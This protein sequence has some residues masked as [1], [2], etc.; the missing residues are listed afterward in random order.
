MKGVQNLIG[1]IEVAAL[2]LPLAICLAV[3]VRQ[4]TQRTR[5]RLAWT[6]CSVAGALFCLALV[7]RVL[8]GLPA[9]DWVEW[10]RPDGTGFC[11]MDG[12]PLESAEIE[13]ALALHV[14]FGLYLL[15]MALI[16]A[17]AA[18]LLRRVR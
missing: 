14:A 10:C 6:G 16:A 9:F 13:A 7:Y 18:S 5:W 15:A 17:G 2:S 12:R 1:A 3:A 8:S 11:A 4:A